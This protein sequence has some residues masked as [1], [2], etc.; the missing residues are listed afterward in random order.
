MRLEN[1]ERYVL[2]TSALLAYYQDE[3]GA[4][5]VARILEA[6]DCGEAT[7]Y[8]SF[9][10]GFEIAYLGIAA[11]GFEEAMNLVLQ[12]RAMNLKEVWAD[13]AVLWEAAKI[14]AG[15]GVS[16]ADAFIAGLAST[17]DATLVH[18]DPEYSRL[19]GQISQLFV[20]VSEANL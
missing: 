2:D 3:D 1:P 16:V 4:D 5:Q 19:A 10:T 20:G 18:R 6:A 8:L 15:G 12:I 9:L 11:Q 14:K 7:V 13:E 17:L